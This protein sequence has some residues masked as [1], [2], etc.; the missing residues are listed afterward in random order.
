MYQLNSITKK[1]YILIEI[2]IYIINGKFKN[3]YNFI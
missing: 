1:N 3:L 2:K